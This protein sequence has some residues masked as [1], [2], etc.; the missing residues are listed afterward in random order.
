MRLRYTKPDGTPVTVELGERPIT[1]GRNPDSD[2]VLLDD[3]ASRIHCGIRLWDGEYY[4]KDLKSRNGTL[5]N[6]RKVEVATLK[7]GDQ[8]R[9]GSTDMVFEGEG[10]GSTT[11][12]Q[13][14]KGEMEQGKGYS[15]ILREIVHDSP[16]AESAP[17]AAAP[18]TP[19]KPALRL[20]AKKPR[21]ILKKKG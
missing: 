9:V 7:P 13:E 1:I 17:A 19:A 21:I 2:I 8:I 14:I 4:I 12:L 15:T 5:V 11:A 18:A 10:G 6:G 16:A 20:P 3:R